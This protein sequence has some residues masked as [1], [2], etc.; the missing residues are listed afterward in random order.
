MF[1]W[2]TEPH[3]ETICM[4]TVS[5]YF[6]CTYLLR[7]KRKRR[8]VV[9]VY[10]RRLKSYIVVSFSYLVVAIGSIDGAIEKVAALRTHAYQ[11]IE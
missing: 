1:S 11:H 5:F 6:L 2:T 9:Y 8:A 4:H 7:S 10:K 3:S